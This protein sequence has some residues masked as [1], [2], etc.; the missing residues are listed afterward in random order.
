MLLNTFNN[1]MP[2]RQAVQAGQET[3]L[4]ARLEAWKAR[5]GE[6]ASWAADGGEFPP[7][8]LAV[9]MQV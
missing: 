2:E 6:N 4:A 5:V 8:G 3:F 1:V 9:T 7:D